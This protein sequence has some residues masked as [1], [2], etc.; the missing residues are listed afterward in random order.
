[1]E[2]KVSAGLVSKITTEKIALEIK[3]W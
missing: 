1:M 3:K 2:Y